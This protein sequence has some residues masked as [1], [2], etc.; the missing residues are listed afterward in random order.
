[1]SDV[2]KLISPIDGSVYAERPAL[3]DAAVDR[4]VS[5]ARTAQ[6]GWAAL[7]VAERVAYCLKALEALKAMNDEVVPE[8][9]WQMGR[10]VRFGGE[11]GGTIERTE[12][13]AKIAAEA[14][15]D[16]ERTD[17]PGFKR[18]LRRV[19]LGVVMVIAPWNY[20]F[21]TAINTIMP[22]LM[23]GNVIVLKHAAQTLLVGERLAKAFEIAGLPK[24]VF[25]NI[26]LT[27]RGTEKLLG[28]G[29][30]DHVNFTGSVGGGRAIEKALAGTFATLGLELGG[31]DPAYVRA[32]AD[33]NY[34]V[35][36][37]VD[38]AFY[39]AGQCCCGI[40]RVYVHE[41]LYDRFVEGFVDLTSQYKLGNP[42]DEATTL[43]PMAQARFAAWIREQTQEA[44]RKGAKAHIDTSKFEAD[45][46]G[47][48][49]LAPQ[50]LTN[51]NHQMSVMREESFGPVVGI[52]KVKDDE[53]ALQFM[54]DSPYGLTASIWT[55]DAQA[56]GEIGD[57]IETGTVFMNRCDYLDPALVWTG[58]KDTGKGAAL[59]EI[60]FHNLTRPKS[61]HFRLEH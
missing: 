55:E 21:M 15:A 12:Y 13:C 11:L 28:S 32:D 40:E 47:T 16:V 36:N 22:A 46:E 49:Y 8:L 30:I 10:P 1:M 34:A 44:L 48:P 61:F 23:A 5:A 37:L 31:K 20:P 42:L 57:R 25:Q 33:L 4:V 56:A 53:E 51:V 19:P 60:G 58:V 50:V 39:N 7:P 38:G 9:A 26:V 52:M 54:N 24:G 35:E 18:Y 41:S 17:K 14:L 43:G 45:K 27:H 3:D 2:I 6:P 29:L 59:S